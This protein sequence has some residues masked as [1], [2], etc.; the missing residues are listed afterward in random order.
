M[1]VSGILENWYHLNKRNL[2]W[3]NSAS[4]YH[5]WLSEIILQQ[6]RV[7]QGLEYYTRFVETYPTIHDLAAAPMDEVLKMWQGLGYYTRARNL[8][9]TAR[10]VA[11][12]FGGNFPQEYEELLNLKGIGKYTAAAIASIAFKKPVAVVD[13]N[14]F[15]V[16]SR[17]FGIHES[18]NSVE[19]NAHCNKLA[20]KL[21]NTASPDIH[22]QSMMEFGALVCTPRKPNCADCVLAATC[23]AFNHGIVADLP[24]R[25]EKIKKKERFFNYLFILCN[26]I[27]LIRK[28][29]GSDIWHSLFE[30]PMIETGSPV[31]LKD[32][33]KISRIGHLNFNR[34]FT[35]Q[36]KALTYRH[37]LT[38][39]LIQCYFYV[40]RVNE[41][42]D[43]TDEGYISTP[44]QN[45]HKYAV[46]RA[47][48]RFMADHVTKEILQ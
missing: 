39:Q 4:P 29:Q 20:A 14:V 38:H 24:A 17:L 8:H 30:F 26:G 6:T 43:W 11:E 9:D 12:K 44:V 35:L 32:L 13:G 22:N 41:I 18:F 16:I 36:D 46:P 42:P 40:L 28:R 27:T 3:R 25:K 10:V 21:L 34:S 1:E 37:L 33:L 47:I 5:I 31:G 19:G 45:L 7:D 48:D 2:P 15:R 23:Y